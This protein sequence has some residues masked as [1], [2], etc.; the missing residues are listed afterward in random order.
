LQRDDASRSHPTDEDAQHAARS[1]GL[2]VDLEG[3]VLPEPEGPFPYIERNQT[4][5][6]LLRARIADVGRL[7]AT[8]EGARFYV[9]ADRVY[10]HLSTTQLQYSGQLSDFERQVARGQVPGFRRA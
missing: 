7:L 3:K 6:A 10:C 5:I 8:V 2:L 4:M 1:T 9:L